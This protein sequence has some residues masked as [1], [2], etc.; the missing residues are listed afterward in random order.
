MNRL[1][2][3]SAALLAAG[4][5]AD[6]AAMKTAAAPL[7][8]C[9]PC[10]YSSACTSPCAPPAAV[11]AAPAPAPA[12]KPYVPPP[13][14][15]LSAAFDP[16][17]G[18]YQA[19]QQVKLTSPTAG[20]EIHYTLDGSAPTAASPVY[21]GPIA[22]AKTTTIRALVTAPGVP[23]SSVSQGE[24]VIA[25]PP[26]PV[27]AAA[28]P[29]P[30]STEHVKVTAKKLELSG[31]VYFDTSKTTIKPTSFGLLDEVAQVLVANP[32]VKKVLIEGHTDNTGAAAFNTKLSQGR[33]EAVREYL[34][35]KGVAADRLAAK[36]YGPTRPIGDN[37]TA[38][39]REENRR[40]EFMIE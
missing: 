32:Q 5:A 35:K 7:P 19:E 27:A 18:E 4:C 30:T 20:A 37:K 12:P 29:P 17:P 1:L 34:V 25:P 2:A 24:Y 16:A 13:T 28:P 22:V 40:V 31:K 14:P 10:T 8:W 38:K 26:A 11:A 39:G 3:V 23:E 9:N 15:A 36:G 33:A 21:S 6:Q